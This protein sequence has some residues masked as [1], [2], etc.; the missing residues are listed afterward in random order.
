[1]KKLFTLL[2]LSFSFI[3]ITGCGEVEPTQTFDKPQVL[4]FVNPNGLP[5]QQQMKILDT[6]VIPSLESNMDFKYISTTDPESQNAFYSYGIRHIPSIVVL[7]KDGSIF[8]TLP[9]GVQN[10]D[11]IFSVLLNL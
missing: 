2:A 5:C 11:M 7:N 6:D 10:K 9:P 3:L 4:T 8:K 1:M